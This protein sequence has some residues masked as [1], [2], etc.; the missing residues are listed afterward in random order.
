[1]PEPVE[2]A[3]EGPGESSGEKDTA[4]E[5]SSGEEESTG[6]TAR[7]EGPETQALRVDFAVSR[8]VKQR[9]ASCA[10]RL[11]AFVALMFFGLGLAAAETPDELLQRADHLKTANN[12]EFQNLLGQLD[13]QAPALSV[14]QR[15]FVD[16]LHAWQL[17]YLG[18]YEDALAAFQ[19]FLARVSDPTLQARARISLINVQVNATHYE[20][21]YA[22]LEALLASA[23][24][25]EDRTA[26]LLSQTVAAT[27]YGDAGQYDLSLR[28]VD[29]ALAFDHGD[30][31]TCIALTTKAGTMAKSGALR[32][33]DASAQAALAAC[34]RIDDVLYANLV[35]TYQAQA[36]IANGRSNEA[37]QL[38][39]P[40]DM[41]ILGTHSAAATS[42]FR[43]ILARC[44]LLA[45]DLDKAREMALS[46]ID[47]GI[48]QAYSKPVAD[49][50]EVLYQAAKRQGQL[51]NALDYHEKYA[52]ADRAYLSDTTARTLAYQMVNQQVRDN[53]HQI[54]VLNERNQVL[55]L[56]GE[57]AAKAAETERL[58]IA[59]LVFGLS[60]I[61]LWA[62][63][64]KLS[65]VRFQKLARR[66]GLTGIL[67]RQHF[68]D[69][70]KVGLQY[71]AK[72]HREAAMILIDLD[73]FKT[74]N[75]TYGHIPGDGVLKQTVAA[76]QELM[77]SIDLFGRLGGEEFGVLLPDC[78][79]ETA[80]GRAEELRAAIAGI[81]SPGIETPISASFGVTS[82]RT[83]GYDLRQMLIHADSALY[84]A[85][86]AGRNRVESFSADGADL[87]PVGAQATA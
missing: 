52:A 26:R 22:T 9:P 84:S 73:N 44:H 58:Y 25:I 65:Q 45:G 42:I 20:D 47:N 24:K 27:L 78:G 34:A 33:D 64:T 80:A 6:K 74:I 61:V 18:R 36:L 85:K 66:D 5:E 29:Q 71:C 81:V 12:S 31:S 86:H 38:L 50:Y 16:Y 14:S 46:A 21:A 53:K 51:Q 35:R 57:V 7:Q 68:M 59:L 70:A 3:G 13:A 75:D 1:L 56:E 11:L 79:V 8:Y 40:H 60:F 63:R 67:N 76:C 83:S 77:R 30:R 2:D 17:G 43:A 87:A 49:A 82:T 69:E 10:G 72:S 4:E 62:W 23:D 39:Q 19:A 54:D 55:K 41:E 37:L 28:Y 48:T 15:D 32:A